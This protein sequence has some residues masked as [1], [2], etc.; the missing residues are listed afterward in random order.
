MADKGRAALLKRMSK[1]SESG[2]GN[3]FK[4][5]RYRVAVKRMQ[6]LNGFKGSRFQ[7]TFVVVNSIKI[8]VQSIKTGEKLDIEP[9][10]I[11]SEVDWLQMLD[12]DDSVG[13]GKVRNLLREM[14]GLKEI[15]D[16][17]YEETLAEV[18]DLCVGE[19]PSRCVC[20]SKEEHC[21][22]LKDPANEVRGMIIDME[23]VRIETQKNKK[24]IV[25]TNWTYAEQTD[26]AKAAMIGWL[27]ALN[28][29]K[30]IVPTQAG[31]AA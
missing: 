26:E 22:V 17:D 10:P 27:D 16:E 11:G 18:C 19:D 13:P 7:A 4:D 14:F 2:V 23:T 30:S 6:L 20:K 1:A 3:N 28:A 5:G 21:D 31:A 12:K 25:V 24:E 8:P 9:N 29:Q 15:S